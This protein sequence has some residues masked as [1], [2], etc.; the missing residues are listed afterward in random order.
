MKVLENLRLK[1]MYYNTTR[2]IYKELPSNT[3]LNE[4]NLEVT[5]MESETDK[6]V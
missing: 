2:A 5:Q 4:R 3:I 6:D 1:A